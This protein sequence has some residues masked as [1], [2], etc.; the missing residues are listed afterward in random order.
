M[1]EST[2]IT[3]IKVT[4]YSRTIQVY[5]TKIGSLIQALRM[6]AVPFINRS[7]YWL[8]R[9]SQGVVTAGSSA[10]L[11]YQTKS[12]L[13]FCNPKGISL[14]LILGLNRRFSAC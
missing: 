5:H 12:N 11:I 9:Y 4:E 2:V 1:Y 13:S 3:A 6:F 7:Y 14:S 8:P 10:C